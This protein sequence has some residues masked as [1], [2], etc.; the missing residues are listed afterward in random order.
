MLSVCLFWKVISG[1]HL[2][3]KRRKNSNLFRLSL[4][5]GPVTLHAIPGIIIHASFMHPMPLHRPRP[6]PLRAFWAVPGGAF[7]PA[8]C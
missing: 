6:R 7:G 1:H 5:Q 2:A 3:E 8:F 4:F